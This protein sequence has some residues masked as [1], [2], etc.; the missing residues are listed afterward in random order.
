VKRSAAQG[1]PVP[2]VGVKPNEDKQLRI[3]GIQPHV[4]NGLIRLHPS[5]NTLLDQLK[6]FPMADHDD[7]PDALQMLWEAFIS[8][9]GG[10]RHRSSGRRRAASNT[11]D[12]VNG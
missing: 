8:R 6:H 9:M 5:Q 10:M 4:A 11:S 12:Y 1:V 7:G 2:A 3:E